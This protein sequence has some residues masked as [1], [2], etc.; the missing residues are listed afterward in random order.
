MLFLFLGYFGGKDSFSRYLLYWGAPLSFAVQARPAKI[1]FKTLFYMLCD[2]PRILLSFL[3]APHQAILS[4][5]LKAS[6]ATLYGEDGANLI[7][8]LDEDESA[9]S[10]VDE[11][12]SEEI[13]EDEYDSEEEIEEDEYDSDDE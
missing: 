12:E 3:P 5:D 2:P 11:S 6:C 9:S 7:L 4:V 10:I 1:L 8:G 13:D